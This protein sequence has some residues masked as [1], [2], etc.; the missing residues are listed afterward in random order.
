MDLTFKAHSYAKWTVT[1]EG[2]YVDGTL[3]KYEDITS[4]REKNKPTTG[5]ISKLGLIFIEISGKKLSLALYYPYNQLM[6][7][8]H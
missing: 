2:L 6:L 1:D 4:I 8:R 7:K 3:Y 5:F